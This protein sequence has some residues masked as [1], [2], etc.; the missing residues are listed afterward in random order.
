VLQLSE[1]TVGWITA[2][3]GEGEDELQSSKKVTMSR[4]H[5]R[6]EHKLRPL[7]FADGER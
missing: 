6:G 1:H 7:G 2:T 4:G 5:R 3:A